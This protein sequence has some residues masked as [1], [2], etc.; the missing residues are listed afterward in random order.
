MSGREALK[1]AAACLASIAR[2]RWALLAS[3][4]VLAGVFAWAGWAKVRDPVASVQAVRDY[5]IL[6][7]GLDTLVGQGLPWLELGLAAFLIQGT[8]A[9]T[10]A[11]VASGLLLAFLG[12]MVS[13]AI[14]HLPIG[15]GCFGETSG[16]G[17]TIW[18]ILRDLAF[19]GL[20]VHVLALGGSPQPEPRAWAGS[21]EE[22]PP[23]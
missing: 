23:E 14:R 10:A 2:S 21:E 9:R 5:R 11:A 17:I 19:L 16:A 22:G 18:E 15:C 3:R 13:A 8:W 7:R 6:P 20:A 1:R 12:A 4:L